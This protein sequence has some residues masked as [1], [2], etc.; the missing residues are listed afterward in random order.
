MVGE[1]IEEGM[2]PWTISQITLVKYEKKHT[3]DVV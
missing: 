3:T 1:I 2:D